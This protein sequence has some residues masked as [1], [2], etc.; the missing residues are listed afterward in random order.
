M[1][2]IPTLITRCVIDNPAESIYFSCNYTIYQIK[3]H[4]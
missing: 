3:A 1:R 4:I 2:T